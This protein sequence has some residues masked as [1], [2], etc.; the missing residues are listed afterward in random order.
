MRDLLGNSLKPG[1]LLW[2]LPKGIP[3]RV[4]RIDEP[5]RLTTLQVG[6]EPSSKTKLVL[7]VTIPIDAM[8]DG[9][10]TQLA[11]F[12]CIVNPDAERIINQMLAEQKT[13]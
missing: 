2:W 3:I 9:A 6:R 1:S 11:D 5:S 12:L 13:Q 8:T 10:E 7:E 4:A